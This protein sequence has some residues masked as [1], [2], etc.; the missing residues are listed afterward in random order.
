MKVICYS[1]TVSSI[2][3]LGYVEYIIC[4]WASLFI[5]NSDSNVNIKYFLI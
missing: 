1:A 5:L 3:S 2:V 4:F